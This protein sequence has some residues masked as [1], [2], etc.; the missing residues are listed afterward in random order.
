MLA[1]NL[2]QLGWLDVELQVP[3]LPSPPPPSQP[4]ACS[5]PSIALDACALIGVGLWQLAIGSW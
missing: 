2:M 5:R 1:G 3:P 4:A